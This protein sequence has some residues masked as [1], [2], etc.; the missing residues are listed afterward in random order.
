MLVSGGVTR[1]AI[2]NAGPGA[3]ARSGS[4]VPVTSRG[5]EPPQQ[6]RAAQAASAAAELFGDTA[7]FKATC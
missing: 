6:A 3:T 7:M 2:E 4:T 1:P 5:D